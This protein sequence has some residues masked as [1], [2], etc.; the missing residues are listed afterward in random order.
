LPRIVAR[1]TMKCI[2]DILYLFF[3]KTSYLNMVPVEYIADWDGECPLIAVVLMG[4]ARGIRR[5]RTLMG[6]GKPEKLERIA[7]ERGIPTVLVPKPC[8]K[9]YID[10]GFFC[11]KRLREVANP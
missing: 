11:L 1:Y 5:A 6:V 4:K 2:S 10:R 9:G 7:L 8:P 3:G